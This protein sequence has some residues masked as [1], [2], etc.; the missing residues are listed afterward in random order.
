VS[1]YVNNLNS[2][3]NIHYSSKSLVIF[4]NGQNNATSIAYFALFGYLI[5]HWTSSEVE[6]WLESTAEM[7]HEGIYRRVANF[8]SYYSRTF[9]EEMRFAT[10]STNVT[11]GLVR[12]F[13]SS[14]MTLVQ[15]DAFGVLPSYASIY[16]NILSVELLLKAVKKDSLFQFVTEDWGSSNLIHNLKNQMI[17]IENWFLSSHRR[18]SELPKKTRAD[19]LALR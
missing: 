12:W 7:N 6:E 17:T 13:L 5:Q 10:L 15:A 11:F 9:F 1:K 4:E 18:C 19:L 14:C 2:N 16:S 8:I 3:L